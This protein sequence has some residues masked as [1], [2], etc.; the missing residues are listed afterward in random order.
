MET[1]ASD[2]I[3]ASRNCIAPESEATGDVPQ[4]RPASRTRNVENIRASS[5]GRQLKRQINGRDSING[6]G[7]IIALDGNAIFEG[8]LEANR[9]EGYGRVVMQDGTSFAGLFEKGQLRKGLRLSSS[10]HAYSGEFHPQLPGNIFHGYGILEFSNNDKYEGE[11]NV[12]RFSGRGCYSFADGTDIKCST[13][14]NDQ[15]TGFTIISFSN[16]S[17]FAGVFS[18]VSTLVEAKKSCIVFADRSKFETDGLEGARLPSEQNGG[19]E[20][21]VGKSRVK[22]RIVRWVATEPTKKVPLK[23]VENNFIDKSQGKCVSIFTSSQL[24][25]LHLSKSS[26]ECGSGQELL[27]YWNLLQRI[28]LTARL[29]RFSNCLTYASF[30]NNYDLLSTTMKTLNEYGNYHCFWLLNWTQEFQTQL[31]NNFTVVMIDD[32]DAGRLKITHLTNRSELEGK[33]GTTFTAMIFRSRVLDSMRAR[34]I[35]TELL[36]SMERL[37]VWFCW[38]TSVEI[39]NLILS[40]MVN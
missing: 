35:M 2:E 25:N 20:F 14:S 24:L 13:W 40:M 18:S 23:Q 16:G 1:I 12:G 26:S 32:D 4:V 17:Q 28:D 11:F 7:K 39:G 31:E 15:P 6:T 10:G 36:G 5:R 33:A 22:E 9:P 8:N 30:E 38:P 34:E 3:A 27:F 21:F 37:M 19:G 29:L